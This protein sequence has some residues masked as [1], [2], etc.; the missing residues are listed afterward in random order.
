MVP[1]VPPRARPVVYPF[2]RWFHATLGG[3]VML[4]VVPAAS[5]L[6]FLAALLSG[7]F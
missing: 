3:P 2:P 6:G 1:Q 5:A 7:I 4:T